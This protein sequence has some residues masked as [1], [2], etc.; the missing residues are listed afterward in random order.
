VLDLSRQ[1]AEALQA[2]HSQG[3]VPR[4][5]KRANLVLQDDGRVK[6]RDFGIARGGPDTTSSLT[7]TGRVVGTPAY[8][9]PEQRQDK[10]LDVGSDL[11]SLGCVVFELLTGQTPFTTRRPLYALMRQHAEDPAQ[12]GVP[13]IGHSAAP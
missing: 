6:I 5:L 4:D 9:S 8:V 7:E 2:A 10:L 12:R 3:I 1:T 11:Y 13:E